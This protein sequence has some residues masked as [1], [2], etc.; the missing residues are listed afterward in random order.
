MVVGTLAC[1]GASPPAPAGR[2]AVEVAAPIDYAAV[3]RAI[4]TD[5]DALGEDYPQLRSFDPRAESGCKILH[6]YRTHPPERRGGWA[7]TVPNPDPDGVWMYVGLWDPTD[8]SE[9][10]AQIHTQPATPTWW[11]GERRVT[12]LILE[13]AET[14]PCA[15]AVLRVLERHGMRRT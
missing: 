5:I 1:A 14:R 9:A 15:G 4:A 2:Q 7:A 3:C 13:G 8:E 11:I 12:F 6:D 10:T